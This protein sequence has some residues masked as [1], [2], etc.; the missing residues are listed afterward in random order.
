MHR[1]H[2]H[3]INTADALRHRDGSDGVRTKFLDLYKHGHTPASALQVHKM[4]LQLELDENHFQ[5][6]ADRR[7]CPDSQWCYR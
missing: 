6:A 7:Q 3:G 2:N 1:T 5:A 4:N